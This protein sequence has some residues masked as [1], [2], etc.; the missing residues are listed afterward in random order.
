M[1]N[2]V[3]TRL[4]TLKGL[5]PMSTAVNAGQKNPSA[6]SETRPITPWD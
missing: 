6:L 3:T 5:T 2:H 4:K 1:A